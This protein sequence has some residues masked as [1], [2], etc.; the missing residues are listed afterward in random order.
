VVTVVSFRS[1]LLKQQGT[2]RLAVAWRGASYLY[3]AVEAEGRHEDPVHVTEGCG[4]L[5]LPIDEERQGVLV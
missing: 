1:T 5:L 3:V 4:T 2:A